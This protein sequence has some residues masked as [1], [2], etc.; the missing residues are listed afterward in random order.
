MRFSAGRVSAG[1]DV[2][3]HECP[4][5]DCLRP[6]RH[7]PDVTDCEPSVKKNCFFVRWLEAETTLSA[8]ERSE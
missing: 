3:D 4:V 2:Q 5:G 7:G 6:K 1:I 8:L